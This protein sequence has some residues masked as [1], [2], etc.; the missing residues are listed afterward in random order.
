MAGHRAALDQRRAQRD[1]TIARAERAGLGAPQG[2][3][4]RVEWQAR[5]THAEA[6]LAERLI[7]GTKRKAL[8]SSSRSDPRLVAATTYWE[9]FDRSLPNLTKFKPLLGD[10]SDGANARWNRQIHSMFKE[11]MSTVTPIGRHTKSDRLAADTSAGYATAIYIHCSIA[12]GYCLF[13]SGA[14]VVGDRAAKQRRL[15][16]GPRGQRDVS[17]GVR[18][19]DLRA[20]FPSWDFDAPDGDLKWACACILVN[21]V[22]RGADAGVVKRGDTPNPRVDLMWSHIVWRTTRLDGDFVTPHMVPSKDTDAR[23]RRT[24]IPIAKRARLMDGQPDPVCAYYWV[25]KAWT[26]REGR[27]PSWARDST[28]F[29]TWADGTPFCSEDVA[30]IGKEIARKAGWPES[31]VARVGAKCFRVGG[32][33]DFR[34]IYGEVE[35]RSILKRRGRWGS[36]IHAIYSRASLPEQLRASAGA[37]D[38]QARDM[39][40]AFPGWAQP[41]VA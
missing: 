40:R 11:F 22:S 25:R 14:D 21:T 13:G 23:Q 16:E 41:A 2:H 17:R 29:F 8:E 24:P 36:D 28:L 20:A 7:Q 15:E 18:A 35:G 10:S 9:L 26:R 6:S 32:A 34:D 5:P 12:A 31:E 33:S 4:E 27:V 19:A 39:E 3:V 38:A 1:S 37:G 30:A